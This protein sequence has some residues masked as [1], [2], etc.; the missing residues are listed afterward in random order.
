[1]N[2]SRVKLKEDLIFHSMSCFPPKE[3]VYNAFKKTPYDEVK[4]VIMVQDPYHGDSQAHGLSFNVRKDVR[5]PPS[6]KNIFKELASHVGVITPGH[7]SLEAWA[8][9]AILT[10]QEGKPL[11]HQKRGWE[12]FTDTFN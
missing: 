4:I 1:M 6:L 8:Q 3:F 10:V 7:G 11:A 2:L 5:L 9:Q 12:Q